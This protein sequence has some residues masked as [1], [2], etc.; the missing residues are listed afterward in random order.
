M[1]LAKLC[2]EDK[3]SGICDWVM[4]GCGRERDEIIKRPQAPCHM[5]YRRVMQTIILADEWDQLLT[6]TIQRLKTEQEI[7]LT[8][9]GKTL[10]GTIPRGNTGTHL[11]TVYV[12]DQGLA[13]VQAQVDHKET[14]LWSHHTS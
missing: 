13:L 1:I 9:D 8:M 11:L 6:T 14:R 12:P 5:T 3:P 4:G 7:I 2:G 10:R